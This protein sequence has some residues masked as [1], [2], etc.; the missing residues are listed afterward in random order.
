MNRP[1]TDTETRFFVKAAERVSIS[2]VR[3]SL[4]LWNEG[5]TPPERIGTNRGGFAALFA[6]NLWFA[7]NML[8]T[9]YDLRFMALSA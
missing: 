9:P 2:N 3:N 6:E 1:Q 8:K 4:T 5:G 7:V